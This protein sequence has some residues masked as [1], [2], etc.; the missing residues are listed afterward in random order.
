[1][2]REIKLTNWK[3]ERT[4][5]TYR[6]P[7]LYETVYAAIEARKNDTP[8]RYTFEYTTDAVHLSGTADNPAA[9]RTALIHMLYALEREITD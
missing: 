9:L 1:M 4:P 2:T 5:G 6:E 8:P 3:I 7:A